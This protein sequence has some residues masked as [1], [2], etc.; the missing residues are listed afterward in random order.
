MI[1]NI[2]IFL[3]I[4]LKIYIFRLTHLDQYNDLT[5]RY[6]DFFDDFEI[7]KFFEKFEKSQN[8]LDFS[9]KIW[10][11]IEILLLFFELKFSIFRPKMNIKY[12]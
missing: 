8:F 7:L 10:K 5:I 6:F 9:G 3:K 4:F 11:K 12:F 1:L 2:L